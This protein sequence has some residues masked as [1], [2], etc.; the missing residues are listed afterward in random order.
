MDSIKTYTRGLIINYYYI[1]LRHTDM[2][3]T[4]RWLV[5]G[6]LN[7]ETEGLIVAG[8]YQSLKT[9]YY[10]NDIPNENID[11]KCRCSLY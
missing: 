8:Q 2:T 10:S 4:T 7:G 5:G 11:S 6:E 3:Q 1:L 9:N